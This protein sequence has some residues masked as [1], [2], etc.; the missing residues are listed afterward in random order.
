MTSRLRFEI[1]A[2]EALD[3]VQRSAMHALF[4]RCYDCVNPDSFERDLNSKNAVVLV[5]DENGVLR[6]FSTQAWFDWQHEGEP[7]RILFSGDTIMEPGYWGSAEL[8]R[9]W[10]E[11]AARL[12]KTE[13]AR[14]L[15]WLLISK[16]YR[17]YLYLPLFFRDF[18]PSPSSS[19]PLS[20]PIKPCLNGS[21]IPSL[22]GLLD[23]VARHRFGSAYDA[24]KG[25]VRFPES[26][27]QLTAELALIPE[28]RRGDPY[29]R[30]FLD[31]NPDFAR[32][33]E[34]AC[35]A[36]V[37]LENTHGLGRRWLEHAMKE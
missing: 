22:Q 37:S 27:G 25:L 19:D 12:L 9:G 36:E 10:C 33:V 32:G 21:S 3:A 4:V 29:V 7:V 11:V 17:T 24:D 16:G 1:I 2:P 20:S 13:P 8:A 30:F 5:R 28:G 18:V 31:R 23:E 35:M 15:F 14:R 6:G 34:L 26:Q